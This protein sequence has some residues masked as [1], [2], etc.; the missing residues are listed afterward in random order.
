ME[1]DLQMSEAT[2]KQHVL[3]LAHER[4]WRVF[5]LTHDGVKKPQKESKGYPDLTLARRGRVMFFELKRMG[6]V[7]TAEQEAWEWELQSYA[8][9][10]YVVYPSDLGGNVQSLLE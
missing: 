2:L 6:E 4:G 9:P 7:L 3:D 8:T 10:Y 1:I 5:H